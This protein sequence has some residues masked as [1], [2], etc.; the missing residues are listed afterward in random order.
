MKTSSDA[1]FKKLPVRTLYIRSK[2][3][4]LFLNL[5]SYVAVLN[6]AIF[7]QVVVGSTIALELDLRLQNDIQFNFNNCWQK[8][9]CPS[10]ENF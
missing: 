7:C 10:A 8:E 4:L 1:A 2:T 5:I 6:T 9:F 3:D